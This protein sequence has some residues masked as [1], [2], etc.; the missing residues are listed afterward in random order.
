MDIQNTCGGS[1]DV[2][3][4]LLTLKNSEKSIQECS[5]KMANIIFASLSVC[6]GP[7]QMRGEC[8]IR[9]FKQDIL[10]GWSN[11]NTVWTPDIDTIWIQDTF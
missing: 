6:F 2:S 10:I 9:L 8:D 1:Q 11:W 4:F 7:M 3:A 5:F